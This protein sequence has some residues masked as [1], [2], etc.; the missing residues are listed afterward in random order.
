LLGA[1]ACVPQSE[2]LRS[3]ILG[4]GRPHPALKNRLGDYTLFAA[5][6]CAFLYPAAQSGEK[7][8]KYGNHG[9]LS[10]DELEVPL[11]V[12]TP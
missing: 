4:P 8:P 9:G 12:V 11:F 2:V 1:A 5:P 3:G 10:A 7:A 6:G